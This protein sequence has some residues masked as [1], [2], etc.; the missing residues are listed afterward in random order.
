MLSLAAAE[1]GLVP[2]A[3]T[4]QAEF[5]A[6]AGLGELL[7]ALQA[8]PGMTAAEY[9]AARA[10]ALHLL[11]PV[12]MGAFRVALFGKAIDPAALPSGFRQRL[13]TGV[14]LPE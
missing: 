10:A 13:L 12:G 14:P 7:V 11:D 2:L 5:L 8:E 9:L 1:R 3:L 6:Q 4:T